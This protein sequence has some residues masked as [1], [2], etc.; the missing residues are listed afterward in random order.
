MKSLFIKIKNLLP[1]LLLISIYF[2][3]VNIEARNDQNIIQKKTKSIENNTVNDVSKSNINDY[4]QRIAIPV[5][6]YNP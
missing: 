1:Y 2:I 5:I 3:F 4:K 6:P